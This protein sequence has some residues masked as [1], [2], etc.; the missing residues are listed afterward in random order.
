MLVQLWIM[1]YEL[2]KASKWE[3]VGKRWYTCARYVATYMSDGEMLETIRYMEK[4]LGINQ[5]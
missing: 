3:P 4:R 5:K 1:F 2:S